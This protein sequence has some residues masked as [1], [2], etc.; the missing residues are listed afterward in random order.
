MASLLQP[1][2]RSRFDQQFATVRLMPAPIPSAE[3]YR[4]SIEDVGIGGY[5]RFEG[6]SYR[7]T[8]MNAYEREGARWPELI[9][10]RLDDGTTQYLEWEKED[11]V[12]VYVS[13]E[14][15]SFEQVGLR[16]KE[17]LWAISEA[18]GGKVE[19]GGATFRY[20]E[21]SA[22]TFFGDGG[23]KGKHFHQYLFASDNRRMFVGIEEWGN[24]NEGYEHNVILSGYLDP[25][26]IDVLVKDGT[27]D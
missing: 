20:H 19:Y 24:E 1:S 6:K 16:D 27:S 21:D 26:A 23:S 14:T 9:L 10:Y 22:V 2:E 4:L 17:S 18:G 8:G 3:R 13:R 15:L 5:I 25:K 11:E 7:V 12:S